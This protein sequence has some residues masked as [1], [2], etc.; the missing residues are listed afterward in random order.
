VVTLTAGTASITACASSC[1]V[2]STASTITVTE[3]DQFGNP[4]SGGFVLF[5]STGTSNT[6]SPA[7]GSTNGSG[8]LTSTF[9]STKAESKTISVSGGVTQTA[10]V[11]VSPA[12]VDLT[13]STVGVSAASMTACSTSCTTGAGTAVTVTVTVRDGFSNVRPGSSVSISA[14]GTVNTFNPSSGITDGNGQV[15]STFDATLIGTHQVSATANFSTIVQTQNVTVNAALAKVS[16]A[17]LMSKQRLPP[18]FV[19]PQ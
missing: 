6:F 4:I 10:G 12:A 1:V 5:G 13:T 15:I 16:G 8:V 17:A 18:L 9:N 14:T 11:T 3:L 19:N 2:G 7:S